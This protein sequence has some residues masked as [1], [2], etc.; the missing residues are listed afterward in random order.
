MGCVTNAAAAFLRQQVVVNVGN[1]TH[2]YTVP[3]LKNKINILHE[4]V[5]KLEISK[6]EYCEKCG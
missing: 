5:W 2:F 6:R 3:S 1:T 4:S